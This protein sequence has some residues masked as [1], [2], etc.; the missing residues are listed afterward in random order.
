[1]NLVLVINSGSSSLKYQVVDPG[2][3]G[4]LARGLV[5]RIGQE[6]S[7]IR[8]EVPGADPLERDVP[9]A[10]HAEALESVLAL[11]DGAG[12][13]LARL[14]AVGHRVV[15]GGSEYRDP[16]V[17]DD[18]VEDAIARIVP[19]APL[20]N[21]AAL[22]GIREMRRLLPS[23]PQVAVF[24]TA[25]HA[26]MPAEA[27]TY[28]LPVD[29][30]RAHRLRKYGFH[31]TSYAYVTRRAAAFLGVPRGEVRLIICHLGNGASM[32]AVRDGV[33]VDTSMG[34]TPLQGLVM[35][36][37]SGDVDPA[38]VFHLVRAAG[39]GLDEV[40]DVLNRQSGLKGLAGHQDMREVRRRANDGDAAARLALDVYAYRVRAYI[41]A[42]LAAVP[43]VQALV[44]T[45]GIGENDAALRQEVCGPLGH[46]GIAVDGERNAEVSGADRAID[47]G[48]GPIRVLVIPTDEEAEIARQ[49]MAAVG[50]DTP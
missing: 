1:M 45:A 28:A 49:A 44:F 26:G 14:V 29:V 19:L 43:G 34:L 2:D 33:G 37:R 21:P 12:P 36:T 30:A 27:Y 46:L 6:G 17:V 3:G 32:A 15:H 7:R 25:F 8:H 18:D 9:L 31:G 20:H 16:V 5:E 41:G 35:G 13:G 48:T 38:V 40:D 22:L 4:W 50:G 47:D 23:V 42:Y 11:L 10:D 24:D 39:M